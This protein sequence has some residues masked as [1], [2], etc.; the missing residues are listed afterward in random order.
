V[1]GTA[2]G[3]LFVVSAPSGA[4]KSTLIAHLMQALPGLVFSVSWTT[5]APR[6]GEVDGVAYHFSDE[7]TFRRKV[8]RGEMLEWAEVH[9]RRYGTDRAE[10]LA[11]LDSGKDVVLD[12]DV[13]GAAQ[14][15]RSGFAA[16]SIFVLPP[17]YEV[18]SARLTGRRTET[19]AACALRLRNAAR[20]IAG[21]TEFDY[22][23]INDDVAVAAAELT[24]VVGAA[25]VRRAR[26]AAAAAVIAAGFPRP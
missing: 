7:A 26:R 22:L 18:L 21:W 11:A 24:A 3:S 25:R 4:G 23:V 15:R 8:E 9:G 20:E 13:Q 2:A 14:I 10:T 5:R 1:S 6:P 16:V 19:D 17:S 12:I